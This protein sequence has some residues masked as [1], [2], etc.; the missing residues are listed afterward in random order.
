MLRVT[1]DSRPHDVRQ[2]LRARRLRHQIVVQ[3]Q[4]VRVRSL[5]PHAPRNLRRELVIGGRGSLAGVDLLP[6]QRQRRMAH[7]QATRVLATHLVLANSLLRQEAPQMRHHRVPDVQQV[8]YRREQLAERQDVA[9]EE[10]KKLDK[11]LINL[12]G[13]NVATRLLEETRHVARNRRRFLFSRLALMAARA[14][15]RGTGEGG[16]ERPRQ[17]S[18]ALATPRFCIVGIEGRLRRERGG[19][20]GSGGGLDGGALALLDHH[21][22]FALV[23]VGDEVHETLDEIFMPLEQL[24]YL[25]ISSLP[26]IHLLSYIHNRPAAFLILLQD[27]DEP[28]VGG[29]F[30]VREASFD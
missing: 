14:S 3:H 17:A 26:Y 29:I 21:R 15:H 6:G 18:R 4:A 28:C 11:L 10:V 30:I 5:R 9:V 13:G 19:L 27:L 25:R 23:F 20:D 2:V 22:H 12:V 16:G 7:L 8:R 1:R 24:D